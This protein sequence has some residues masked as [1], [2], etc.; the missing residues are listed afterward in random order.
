MVDIIIHAIAGLFFQ[1]DRKELARR[2]G[3]WHMFNPIRAETIV[4]VAT[5]I[6]HALEEY[7]TSGMRIVNR[8]HEPTI[9]GT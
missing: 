3:I 7:A 2:L 1:N 5:L 8:V 6:Q 9:I 4:L